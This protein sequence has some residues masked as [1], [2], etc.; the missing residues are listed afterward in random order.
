MGKTKVASV[1]SY[2]DNGRAGAKATLKSQGP[3]HYRRMAKARWKNHKPK[4]S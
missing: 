4:R 3:G 2:S 1:P